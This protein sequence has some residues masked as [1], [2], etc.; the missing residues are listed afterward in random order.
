M[1]GNSPKNIKITSIEEKMREPYFLRKTSSSLAPPIFITGSAR[2]GTSIV[3]QLISSLRNIE[4]EFEPPMLLE[5]LARDRLLPPIVFR[6]LIEAY[7]YEEVLIG[8]LSGRRMNTRRNDQSSIYVSKEEWDIERRLTQE[9]RKAELE[10]IALQC[11]AAVKIP[12]L[13]HKIQRLQEIINGIK[14]ILCIRSPRATINS[15]QKK[16]WFRQNSL[17]NSNVIFPTKII[18]DQVVPHWVDEVD[19][20]DWSHASEFNRCTHYYKKMTNITS[21]ENVIVIDYDRFIERP[22]E[23]VDNIC[24]RLGLEST[25]MT[26]KVVENILPQPSSEMKIPDYISSKEMG[27]LDSMYERVRQESI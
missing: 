4:Y 27:I 8:N 21:Q 1:T 11:T 3:G 2:S 16:S 15:L 22:R 13:V 14:I 18:G 12:S 7:F 23:Q 6:D 25:K 20:L 17:E 9:S 10:K 24:S 19:F 5:L 26:E